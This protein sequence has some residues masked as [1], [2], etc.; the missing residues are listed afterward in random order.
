MN[1]IATGTVEHH[2]L[3][4]NKWWVYDVEEGAG[5]KGAAR[6]QVYFLLNVKHAWS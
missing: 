4:K 2:F 3:A 6:P 1:N 5:G